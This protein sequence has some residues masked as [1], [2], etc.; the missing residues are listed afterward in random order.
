MSI[1]GVWQLRTLTIRYCDIQSGSRG[2]RDF[3]RCGEHGA[4]AFASAHPHLNIHAEVVRGR[5]PVAIGE[6]AN[7]NVIEHGLRDED[8]D[9]VNT[10]IGWLRDNTGRKVKKHPKDVVPDPQAVR[11]RKEAYE[12]A[13]A[14]AEAEGKVFDGPLLSDHSIQGMW[15]NRRYTVTISEDDLEEQQQQ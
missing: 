15:D 2:V 10:L 14:A 13:E 7:G 1:R 6:Y 3:L 9:G 12:A 11:A 5:H 8:Q 4:A